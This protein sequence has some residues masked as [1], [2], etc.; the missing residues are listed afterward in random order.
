[1]RTI[2]NTQGRLK[3]EKTTMHHMECFIANNY[4]VIQYGEN[5]FAYYAVNL[6]KDGGYIWA[7]LELE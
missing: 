5:F 6:R 4:K 2:N 3:F 7:A 1:M